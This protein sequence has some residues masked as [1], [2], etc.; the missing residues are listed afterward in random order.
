MPP[1][2]LKEIE[3]VRQIPGSEFRRWFA[4]K[5]LELVVWYSSDDTIYGFQL[6]YQVDLIEKSLT[7]RK[8]TGY[9]HNRIDDGEHSTGKPKK[10][11]MLVRDGVCDLGRL[12]ALFLQASGNLPQEIANLVKERIM[13][14]Q[15]P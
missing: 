5:S 11:P 10:T 4:S 3:R 1:D 14:R 12:L 6:C 9:S 8:D 2:T 7:W 13:E 15:S